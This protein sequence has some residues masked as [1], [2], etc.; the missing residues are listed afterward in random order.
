MMLNF[1]HGIV[2][3]AK[4]SAGVPNFLQLVNA[5]TVRVLAANTPLI[6]T[7]ANRQADYLQTIEKQIDAWTLSSTVQPTHLYIDINMMTATMSYG[8]SMLQPLYSPKA[9]TNPLD[10]QHWFNTTTA[11][12]YVFSNRTWQAVLRIFVATITGSSITYPPF[13]TQIGASNLA[14][15]AGKIIFADD[16]APVKNNLVGSSRLKTLLIQ[17]VLCR[18]LIRYRQLFYLRQQK[19]LLH[20]THLWH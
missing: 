3:A 11:V 16:G 14:V 4:T 7:I 15:K 19:R 1:R 2:S 12:M 18:P 5:T 8:S 13:G 9:P 20:R 10:D 17:T 6:F